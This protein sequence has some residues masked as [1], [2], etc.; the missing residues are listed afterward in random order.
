M[1]ETITVTQPATQPRR[2]QCRHIF[3]DGHRCG[4]PCLRSEDFCFYHHTSH[5]RRPVPTPVVQMSDMSQGEQGAAPFTL[6]LPEDRSA[7]QLAIG[8][9]LNRL[10]SNQLDPR[11]AGLLLYGLQIASLNLPH[12]RPALAQTAEQPM[13]EDVIADP[14]LGTVAPR[15]ELLPTDAP[16]P[17]AS[18][19][20]SSKTSTA[21][22]I[23]HRPH[24]PSSPPP[25]PPSRPPP[26]PPPSGGLSFPASP[27]RVVS[28]AAN[29]PRSPHPTA[30]QSLLLS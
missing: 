11:R 21:A 5:A 18:S 23:I 22:P 6:P 3:T 16:A 7:I 4:S 9:I 28:G 8:E 27:E 2:F 12:A 1:Y 29:V 26:P 17:T 19:P 10:A 30:P 24:S 15:S 25:S 20:A 13:V 14:D